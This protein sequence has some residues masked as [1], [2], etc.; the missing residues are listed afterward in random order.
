MARLKRMLLLCQTASRVLSLYE[1]WFL[2]C[3]DWR[4]I[5]IKFP[6][7]PS[8]LPPPFPTVSSGSPTPTENQNNLRWPMTVENFSLWFLHGNFHPCRT[9]GVNCPLARPLQVFPTGASKSESPLFWASII[10]SD[11]LGNGAKYGEITYQN[12]T[13]YH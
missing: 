4:F 3:N 7:P 5:C 6:F 10:N 2:I 8:V 9:A 12:Y 13:S 11:M 1:S